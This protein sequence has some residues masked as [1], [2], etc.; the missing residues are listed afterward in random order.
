MADLWAGMIVKR[1]YHTLPL[2]PS[3]CSAG[4]GWR[5]TVMCRACGH[6]SNLNLPAA[7]GKLGRW[8]ATGSLKSLRASFSDVS[9]AC[10]PILCGYA[11]VP[12]RERNPH[13]G[14]PRILSRPL[15]TYLPALPQRMS[16]GPLNGRRN[17]INLPTPTRS[18]INAS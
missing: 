17:K 14:D 6:K 1:V 15:R 16:C 18:R 10:P 12:R 9:A 2:T 4:Q 5:V 8:W 13:D 7:A 11:P 3:A